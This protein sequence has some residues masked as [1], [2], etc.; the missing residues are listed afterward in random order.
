MPASYI[1]SPNARR[2]ALLSSFSPKLSDA[3]QFPLSAILAKLPSL[4]DDPLLDA[5]GQL[6]FPTPP[7][8]G[9]DNDNDS[10][11]D[12]P[13]ASTSGNL[14]QAFNFKTVPLPPDDLDGSDSA[15][16][17]SSRL[18]TGNKKRFSGSRSVA[19][20]TLFNNGKHLKTDKIKDKTSTKRFLGSRSVAWWTRFPTRA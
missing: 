13:Q 10:D 9:L 7:T 4:P 17:H 12:L 16:D 8:P 15:S 6:I 5:P 1:L 11:N 19:W 3:S 20:W 2:C 14:R 18:K